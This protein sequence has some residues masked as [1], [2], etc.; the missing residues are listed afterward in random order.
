MSK[1]VERVNELIKREIAQIILREIEFPKNTLVTVTR[2]ETAPNLIET[3]VFISVM[4][5]PHPEH[6]KR[7][8]LGGAGPEQK[9][10]QVLN[11]LNRRIFGLQQ[12]INK[13]LRMR[14]IPKIIFRIESNIQE[15][16]RVERLLEEIRDEKSTSKAARIEEIL[17]GLKNEEK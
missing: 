12:E 8:V 10:S 14:P 7:Y 1:R 16:D 15:A 4:F 5:T 6:I 3:L 9:S 17:E 11:I 13:R 2:V